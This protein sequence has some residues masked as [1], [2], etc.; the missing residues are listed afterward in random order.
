MLALLFFY[1]F[2]KEITHRGFPFK[3][4]ILDQ[5]L[6]NCSLGQDQPATCSGIAHEPRI[7]FTL[8]VVFFFFLS[9]IF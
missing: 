7:I 4:L 6:A 9:N 1:F 3:Y 8:K 2:S 5:G